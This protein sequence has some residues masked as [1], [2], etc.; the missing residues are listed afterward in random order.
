MNLR[1]E[2]LWEEPF[3]PADLLLPLSPA[4]E[5]RPR[6]PRGPSDG[7]SPTHV[8]AH[9]HTHLLVGPMKSQVLNALRSLK[10]LVS[11]N[12][13][14]Q[15]NGTNINATRRDGNISLLPSPP[16][17]TAPNVSRGSHDWGPSVTPRQESLKRSA[18]VGSRRW[19]SPMSSTRQAP[20]R[21][22]RPWP[23]HQQLGG[24]NS[25]LGTDQGLHPP[26]SPAV[27]FLF[28][29]KVTFLELDGVLSRCKGRT[30]KGVRQRWWRRLARRPRCPRET[31][32][33]DVPALGLVSLAMWR[34]RVASRG[35]K[36]GTE[37][38]RN[39]PAD[40][41]KLGIS[42]LQGPPFTLSF[43]VSHTPGM[44]SGFDGQRT[45][46]PVLHA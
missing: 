24:W 4:P 32:H 15:A 19:L 17:H 20:S 35:G 11:V 16:G 33:Q 8:R 36:Q 27:M 13:T 10:S 3:F 29:P 25:D 7:P 37:W 46:F 6:K 45:C 1:L 31:L 28:S 40:K 44:D 26:H 38:C 5:T 14:K 21:S 23:P 30:T 9:T 12:K 2:W 22:T 34:P 42:E 39:L 18:W 43:T 41:K